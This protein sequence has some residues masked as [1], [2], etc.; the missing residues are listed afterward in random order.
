MDT[1]KCIELSVFEFEFYVGS[2]LLNSDK[3]NISNTKKTIGL[4][5]KI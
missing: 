5:I 1:Y 4:R 3:N 2:N